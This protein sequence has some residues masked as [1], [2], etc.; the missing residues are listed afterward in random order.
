MLSSLYLNFAMKYVTD[1]LTAEPNTVVALEDGS[2]AYTDDFG[3]VRG[4]DGNPITESEIVWVK[5]QDAPDQEIMFQTSSESGML[6][7][8][9]DTL[10]DAWGGL[11]QVNNWDDGETY[12]VTICY[13]DQE[14]SLTE[15][16]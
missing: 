13:A 2:P 15:L 4:R 3:I 5:S 7:G 9:D 6:V 1:N 12:S 8:L 16:E 10:D 14:P 11:E